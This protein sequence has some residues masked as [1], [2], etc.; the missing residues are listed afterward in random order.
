MC[1]VCVYY[2]Y[3]FTH[4]RTLRCARGISEILVRLVLYCVVLC[5][6]LFQS[7][8]P[9]LEQALLVRF[10]LIGIIYNLIARVVGRLKA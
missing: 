6:S 5:C 9:M 2:A 8:T 7:L 3:T 10:V 4:V 1:I